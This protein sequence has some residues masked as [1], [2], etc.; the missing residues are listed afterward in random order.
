MYLCINIKTVKSPLHKQLVLNEMGDSEIFEVKMNELQ[1]RQ[2][3]MRQ[4]RIIVGKWD[5]LKKL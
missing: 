3:D 5:L 4:Q 2:T 1:S